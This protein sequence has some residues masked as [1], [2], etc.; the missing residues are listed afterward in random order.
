MIPGMYIGLKCGC[1][2][3]NSDVLLC[4]AA[5]HGVGRAWRV[6]LCFVRPESCPC[7]LVGYSALYQYLVFPAIALV[8]K[9]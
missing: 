7:V 3:I 1:A 5:A 4:A 8:A 2:A 9:I 6:R